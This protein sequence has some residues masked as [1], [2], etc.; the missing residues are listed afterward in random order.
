MGAEYLKVR[1]SL[2]VCKSRKNN[3]VTVCFVQ[4]YLIFDKWLLRTNFLVSHSGLARYIGCAVRFHL[5]HSVLGS[6]VPITHSGISNLD[7]FL[8]ISLPSGFLPLTFNMVGC[9]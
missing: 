8:A 2:P 5:A 9:W 3:F 1:S 6:P 7:T 4:I